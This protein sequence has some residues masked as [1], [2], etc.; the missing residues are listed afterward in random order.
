M[1]DRLTVS[2][3]IQVVDDWQRALDQGNEVCAVFSDISKAF[4]TVS[5]AL[6]TDRNW[7]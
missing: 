5:H 1:C 2:A 4:D 7:H 3:L 6:A